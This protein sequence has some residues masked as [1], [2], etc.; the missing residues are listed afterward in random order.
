MSGTAGPCS[1]LARLRDSGLLGV[2]SS[3]VNDREGWRLLGRADMMAMAE[4]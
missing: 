2:E 4:V 3:R 1:V